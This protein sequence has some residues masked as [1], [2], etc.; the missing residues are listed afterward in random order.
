MSQ[1]CE[2]N[3]AAMSKECLVW[4]GDFEDVCVVLGWNICSGGENGSHMI[5]MGSA[6]KLISAFVVPQPTRGLN[7]PF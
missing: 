3:I 2:A 7:H 4:L 1:D 5:S 6:A